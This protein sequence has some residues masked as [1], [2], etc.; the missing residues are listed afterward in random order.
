MPCEH[1]ILKSY[2]Y[3]S[4]VCLFRPLLNEYANNKSTILCVASQAVTSIAT[5]ITVQLCCHNK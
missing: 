4:A 1:A 3:R 5:R 2:R